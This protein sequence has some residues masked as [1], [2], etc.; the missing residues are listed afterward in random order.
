MV[1]WIV[2]RIPPFIETYHLTLLTLIWST[3]IVVC[4]YLARDNISWL[5]LVSL[6]IF[7]QYMSDVLDGAVVRYRNTGL[8]R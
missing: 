4:S 5:W 6:F 2:P 8:V 7:L 3:G 1:N